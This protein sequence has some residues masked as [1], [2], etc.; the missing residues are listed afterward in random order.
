MIKISIRA[1]P[2]KIRG[3]KSNLTKYLSLVSIVLMSVLFV[4]MNGNF[5]SA[6]NI[7][8]ILMDISPILVIA[9]G[10]ALP[11]MLGSIDL[12]IG[13]IASCAAVML[14]VLLKEIGPWGYAV[15]ILYGIFA[16]IANG[17]LHTVLRV[18]SFIVT[19][20]TQLV[21]QSAAYIIS[22]GQPLA[23]LPAVWPY[24][25]WAK[26]TLF[27]SIPLLFLTALLLTL[28]YYIFQKH[29]PIGRTILDAGANERAARMSG[30]NVPKAKVVAFLLSGLGAAAGGIF[31]AAKLKSG[32]PTVGEQYTLMAIAS[33]VL[34][35]VALTGG[36]GNILMTLMGALLITIIQNG[37]NV[38][39]VDGLWQQVVFGALVLFAIYINSDKNRK[40]LIAK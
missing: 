5:L 16:G 14:A 11:L 40:D 24:V 7:K 1:L 31:F 30:M 23:M 33:A 28:L 18:P 36:K 21:W 12:S 37:M 22:G 2:E 26:V 4:V 8:N 15:V 32:I 3:N 38:V 34:G 17:L 9:A 10:V 20:G 25:D 19:L 29:T 39:G 27:S 6:R 13:S 35:G